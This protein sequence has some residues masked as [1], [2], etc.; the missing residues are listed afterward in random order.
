MKKLVILLLSAVALQCFGQKLNCRGEKVV[1]N[2]EIEK[3]DKFGAVYEKR[4]IK[5]EYDLDFNLKSLS[6]RTENRT[7]VNSA[8]IKLS[9]GVLKWIRTDDFKRNYRLDGRIITALNDLYLPDSE[10]RIADIR[11]NFTYKNGLLTEITRKWYGKY[12]GD[13]EFFPFTDTDHLF[14]EYIDGNPYSI[15]KKLTDGT[16]REGYYAN[17]VNDTN[18][19]IQALVWDKPGPIIV[20]MDYVELCTEWVPFKSKNLISHSGYG[21]AYN[22]E[23][24]E[25]SYD[26]SDDGN[27]MTLYGK[28]TKSDVVN[29]VIR[30]GYLY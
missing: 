14:I 30:F 26:F 20:D 11:D 29:C 23:Y 3:T 24:C 12:L 13:D 6:M 2:L 1:S 7:S 18:I 22:G 15:S 9:N 5:F 28:S 17:Y 25:I 10:G 8:T 27:I 16:R 4:S 19:N 21:D